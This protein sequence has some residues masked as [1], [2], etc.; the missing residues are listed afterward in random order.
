VLQWYGET[1]GFWDG[2]TLITHTANIQGWTLTHSMF[3]TSNKLETIETWKPALDASGKFIGL[4]HET[5]FYDTDAFVAPVRATYRFARRAT[6]DD[7]DRRY[8]YIE[9][10]SNIQNVN[11]KPSQLPPNDPR[12]TDYYGRPWAKNWEKYFE[13]DW[14]KPADSDLPPG[15]LDIFK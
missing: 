1:I 15:I 6:M 3:E 13:A 12:Y 10:L 5:I 8:T 2:T 7:P 11:G 4:D 9:C 14:D